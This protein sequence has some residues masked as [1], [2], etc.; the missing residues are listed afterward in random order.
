[1]EGQSQRGAQ[2]ASM[3]AAAPSLVFLCPVKKEGAK[4]PLEGPGRGERGGL[5]PHVACL[6]PVGG[7]HCGTTDT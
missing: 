6:I 2:V 5:Q 4:P 1:M 7:P 3:S